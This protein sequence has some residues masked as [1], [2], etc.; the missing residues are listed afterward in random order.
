MFHDDPL[1][2]SEYEVGG[3]FDSLRVRPFLPLPEI[4][5]SRFEISRT[6]E[7]TINGV[8]FSIKKTGSGVNASAKISL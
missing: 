6:V 1:R 7:K 3:D 5:N 8:A 4:P 2:L